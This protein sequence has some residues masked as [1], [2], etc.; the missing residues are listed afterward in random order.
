MPNNS[1][2]VSMTFRSIEESLKEFDSWKGEGVGI[3][4]DVICS[5]DEIISSLKKI[6][7]D[8]KLRLKND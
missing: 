7:K 3:E 1:F 2:V 4:P 8:K 5:D 6:T